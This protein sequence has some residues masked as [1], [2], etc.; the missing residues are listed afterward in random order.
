MMSCCITLGEKA[1]LKR[2][3]LLKYK[4]SQS[5][6]QCYIPLNVVNENAESEQMQ[7]HFYLFFYVLRIYAPK[8]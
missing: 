2:N 4:P 1:L 5:H 6:I 8:V 3:L 7:K